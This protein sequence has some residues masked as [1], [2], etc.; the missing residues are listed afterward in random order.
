M[1]LMTS[2]FLSDSNKKSFF[3]LPTKKTPDN[4]LGISKEQISLADIIVNRQLDQLKE[5]KQ[6]EMIENQKKNGE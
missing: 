1:S 4:L 2:V 6:V 3:N 5:K